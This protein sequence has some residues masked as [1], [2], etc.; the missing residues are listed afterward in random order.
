MTP[1]SAPTAPVRILSAV[2]E[3]A[4]DER[5]EK[6]ERDFSVNMVCQGGRRGGWKGIIR[7]ASL[8]FARTI[9]TSSVGLCGSH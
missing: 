7:E 1:A 8:R 5:L 2:G 3:R 9:G 4:F 6:L